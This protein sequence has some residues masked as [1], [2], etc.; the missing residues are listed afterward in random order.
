MHGMRIYRDC[1]IS[2]HVC[3][4]SI[5]HVALV[6]VTNRVVPKWVQVPVHKPFLKTHNTSLANN[7]KAINVNKPNI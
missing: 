4:T 6:T 2:V 3:L 5:E 7:Q 1:V